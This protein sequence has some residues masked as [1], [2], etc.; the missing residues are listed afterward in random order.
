MQRKVKLPVH[1]KVAHANNFEAEIEFASVK[2]VEE[3]GLFEGAS[4]QALLERAR[5]RSKLSLQAGAVEYLNS[6]KG[7]WGIISVGW[8]AIFIRAVLESHGIH[9]SHNHLG[10]RSNEISFDDKGVGTGL[11]SKHEG[12]HRGIRTAQDKQ[13]EMRI[14]IERFRKDSH[15]DDARTVRHPFTAIWR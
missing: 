15:M 1:L 6:Y 12:N 14:M 8:S 11:I 3:G 2:R 10:I 4:R 7:S 13:R 5:D 9:F